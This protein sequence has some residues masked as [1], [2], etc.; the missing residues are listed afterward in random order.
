MRRA[1]LPPALL[2]AFALVVGTGLAPSL[3][4]QDRPDQ[5]R[6]DQQRD[7]P[8]PDHETRPSDE[9]RGAATDEHRAPTEE[10]RAPDEAHRAGPPDDVATLR[11]AHPRSSARCHDGFFTTTR[12]RAHACSKHGGID[13]WLLL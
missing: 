9:P 11:H 6:P 12:D 13:I 5:N 7:Q 10:H 3:H 2:A 4:A 1:F 8:A